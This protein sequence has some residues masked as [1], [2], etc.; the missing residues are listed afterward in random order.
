MPPL[1]S[2]M[3]FPDMLITSVPVELYEYGSI[4][5]AR[6]VME[7]TLD[8]ALVNMNFYEIDKLNSHQILSDRIVFCV[9]PGH[10]LANEKEVSIEML[11]VE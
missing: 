11:K 4:R 6:L 2:T 1:L 10:H 7:E 3:F 8:L 9:S 5:A